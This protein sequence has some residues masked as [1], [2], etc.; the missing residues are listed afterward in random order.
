[1]TVLRNNG[2]GTFTTLA[3]P[4]TGQ[5]PI[6]VAVADFDRDGLPDLA[7]AD[8]NA[9]R[10][11]VLRNN[12]NG[13]FSTLATPATGAGPVCVA[14]A[15]FDRDGLP[16]LATA[17]LFSD[18]VT[19]LRNNGDGT[20]S[21]LATPATGSGPTSVA[22]A[23]FDRDGRP[24]LATA[25]RGSNRVTVLRAVFLELSAAPAA[26]DFPG[27]D[28]AAGPTS[29]KTSTVTNTGDDPV[30]LTAITLGGTDA[31]H[32]QRLTTDLADCSTSTT[33]AAGQACDLRVQ[34]DPATTGAKS[35]TLTVTS[36]A[37]DVTVALTGTGTQ[38]QLSVA[39]GSLDFDPQD[40]DNGATAPRTSTV[41]NT[42]TEPVAL[43]AIV[44]T[45]HTLDFER[46]TGNPTDC[47][48]GTSLIS[49]ETCDLRERFDPVSTGAKSA[50][51]T[52]E[53]N[54]APIAVALTGTGTQTQLSR[55][56]GSLSFQPR[57]ID[58]G[59]A[60]VQTSTVT[61]SGTESVAL[62]AITIGGPGAASFTR[63]TTNPTDCSTTTTL[64]AEQTCDLR[65]QFDPATTGAQTAT[66]TVKSS[67]PDLTVDLSGPG[68]QTQLSRTPTA[69]ALGSQDVDDGPTTP[70]QTSTVRNTGTEQVTLSAIT[71]GG[72]G[73]PSFARLT[74][75][76]ADCST[77]TTLNAGQTCTLRIQFDPATTGAQ[78]ATLTVTSNAAAIAV[79]LSGTGTQT[80]LSRSPTI[81]SFEP[82]DIDNGPAATQT[83]TVTNTGTER[84]TIGSITTTG[85]DFQRLTTN[86]ADCSET[87]TL[88]ADQTCT[89]RV[90]F[91]PETTGAKTGTVSVDSS[92]ADITVD[93][94]GTGTQTELSREPT[95]L[96]LGSQDIDN[97][98]TAPHTST[99]TNTGTQPVTISAITLTG[100]DA[101]S[102]QRLPNVGDCATSA[103]LA[104]GQTCELRVLFDPASVGAKSA[105]LTVKSNAA[106]VTVALSAT[107]TQTQLS[108]S[109]TALS[110]GSR[111]ID[112][113]PTAAQTSTVTN[114]GTEPV[115]ITA[116]TI[117]GTDAPRFERL[118][119]DPADCSTTTTLTAGQTCTLRVQLDPATTG[120]QTATLT[121][122]SNAAAIT[123]DLSGTGTQTQLSR[124]PA[125]LPF[126]PQD[127]DNGPTATQTSTVTNSGS[128]PVTIT[129]VTITGTDAPRFERLTTNPGD[130]STTTTLTAGQTCELRVRFDPVTTGATVA[131]LT[132]ASNAAAIT[133]DLSGT[134]TQTQ[135]SRSP[136]A[137]PFGPQDIDNGPTATQ[138]STVTNT[139]TE[140]VT[141]TAITLTGTGAAS[142]ARLTANP[143]DCATATLAAGQT[144]D[145]RVQFDPATT[146]AQTATLTVKSSVPDLTVTLSGT[147]TQTQLSRSPTALAFGSRDIDDGP[148]AAQ[149]ATV[150]NTGTEPVTLS[151]ITLAGTGAASFARL[152][153]NPADCSTTTTL[154]AGQTCTLRLQF[155]PDTTGAQSATLT[156]T[157]NAADI[158]VTLSGTGTQTE[159]SPSPGALSFGSRDIDD[160]ATA[161]QTSTVTNTGTQPVTLT[162]I[163]LAGSDPSQ[164]QRLTGA[165]GDCTTTTT[166]TAGQTCNL[167]ARFDPTAT[168]AKTATI[169]VTSN[170]AAI[171][172]T[173]SGTG[174]QT[175]LSRSPAALSFGLQD[176]DAGATAAQ[177]STVTNTG[178]EPVTLTAITLAGSDP[179]QFQRLTG[180]TA[181]CTTTTML[182]AGQTCD[183]RARFDPTSTG[184]K[185]ATITVDSN[186]AAIAV[187]LT[188][189][190]T[191][192]STE[193]SRAPAAL[194]FGSKDIDDGATATQAS[195]VTNTGTEPVT[196]T[197]I[198]LAGSNPGEFQLL[199]GAAVD[200]TTTTTLT[201]GETCDLRARFDPTSTGAKTATIT[202][203][204]NAADI[205]VSLTGTGTQA[206][207]S[208]SPTA[209]SFGPQ[210]IDAGATAAQASTVTNTGTEPVTFTAIT[211]GGADPDDFARLT[212]TAGDCASSTSLTSGQSCQLRVQF[213]PASVG[214]KSA[215]ATVTSNAADVV[216]TLSGTGTQ[217]QLSRAPDSLDLGPQD[218]DD[219]PT[220]AQTST[221]TNTGTEPV[222]ISAITI[223]GTDGPRFERL[224]TNL[225]D[226]S[227]ST[228]LAAGQT[229]DLR[230]RFD[231]ATIG[232]QT[233]TLTV[234]SNAAPVAVTL[235]GTGTQTQLSRSPTALSFGLQDIDNGATAAQT[236]T[237]TN[238][239]TEPVTLSAITLTG[240]ASFARLTTN[241]ADCS[242]TTT[243]TAGQTCTLRVQFDPATTG[244]QSAT[245]TVASDAADVAVTLTG[246][247]TQTELSRSPTAL[248]FGLQD[249]DNGATAP[250]TSTVTNTGTQPV[251]L[252]AITIGG[253][254][255]L[256][257]VRLTSNPADCS[258]TT[259]LTAGQTCD[260]RI[261]FDPATTGANTATITVKSNAP[262]ITVALSGTGTQTQLSRSP[263]SLAFAAQDIDEGATATQTSTVTNTGSEPVTLTAITLAG[264]DPGEFQRL[265]GA[266]ADCTTTTT[267][268]AGET[269]D[270]RA[271]FDPTTTGAKS[272]AL[273]A[274]SNAAAI[275]VTLTGTGT[276]T[277]L[278]R[279]PAA[280]PL[281]PQDIDTGA[282]AAQT[283]T[284]TNTG[285][286]PVT[287][288]AITI[289]GPDAP[290][291]QRLTTNPADCSTTTTLT[292]GLTCT[293]RVQFDPASTGAK[294]ATLT[295]A[296]NAA[297]IT[298]D[299]SGT[300]TQT[301]LSRS[302]TALAF[303]PQDID[304]GPTP[305][306]TSTVTNTG[307][308]PV[309][310]T[311]ITIGGA[312][313]PRFARLTG[314][315]G[316]CATTTLT[317]GQTCDLR[318][319]F[320][321]ATTGANVATLTVKSNAADVT[322]ALSGTGTQ[323]QL[324]RSPVAMSFG[325]RD[326]DDGPTAAQT[327]TVTN[328]GT[329]PVTLSAITLAGTGAA[330]FARLTTNP[331]DCTTTTTLA[332][333]QTCTLRVQFDPATTGAQTA[334]LNVTSNAADIAVTLTGSGT[335]TELSRS[336]TA[337]SFGPQD[338]DN[339]P[340][341]AQTSTV[342][343][344]GTQP[345]TLSAITIAGT[346]FQRLTTNPADCSTTTTLTA[347]QTCQLRV[348]FDPASTGATTATLTV[349]SNAAAITVGLSGTGTQMQLAR[350]PTALSFGSR[351]IDDGATATQASTVTNTGSEPVT[352]T[353]IT[354][355]GS[356]ASQFQR[357]TGATADCMTTTVL[358]AGETCDLRAR[359]DPTATGAK[360]ATLTVTSNAAAITVTLSG[361]G[362]Q[363]E[364]SRSP[365][366]LSLGPRDIDDGP[367][368]T[369][370]STVT[371]TGTQQVTLSAI[372][373]TGTDAPRFQRLTTNPADC[374][375]T[376]TLTAGQTCLLRVQFDPAATGA[377]T[378]LLTV[379][380]NAPDVTVALS[381]SGTQ[382][383]LSRS[384]A[385]LSFGPQDIDD[386]P[387]DTHTSTVTNTGTEPVTLTAITIAGADF[388]R[389]T[390]GLGDCSTSTTLAAGQACELR[391][392]FDPAT[393]GAKSAAITVDSSAADITVTLSGTGTQ[394]QLERTPT[395]LAFG[396]R[397]IDDGATAPQTSTVTNTG[398]EPVE[399][400]AIAITGTDAP[401]FQRLTTNPADCSTTSTLAAGQTCD[402]R[403]RFDPA[404]TGAQTATLTVTSEATGDLTVELSGS[405]TQTELSRSP[406]ALSFGPQ[407]ID[408]GA[409]ATQTSTVTNT[410]SEP[411]AFSGITLA[412]SDLSQFQR[413]TGAT[414]DCTTT[415]TL[416]AGETCILRAR[417]DPTSAG[418]KT[419]TI[420]VGSNADDSTVALSGTGT[421]TQLSRA[422]TALSFGSRGIDDGATTTQ[423]STVTNTGSEPVTL[424]AITLTGSDASQFQR[425]T[426]ATADCATTTVL[427]AGET[428]DLR[429]RFDPTATGAKSATLTVDSNAA[430]ITIT[431]TGT[432]TQTELSPDPGALSFGPRDID[433]G[434]TV[435]QAS[436]VTNT[437]SEPVTLTAIAL[438][439]TDPGHFAR[440]TGAASDCTTATT[441]TAGQTCDLRA[442]FDPAGT[443]PKAATLTV[444]SS[445]PVLTLTLTGTGTQA[446]LSPTP[447]TLSFGPRDVDDGPAAPQAS[448]ITNTGTEPVK[449][450][451][452][453]L[454]GTDPGQ[455]ARVTGD[456]ADCTTATTLSSGAT[457][458]L[459]ALYDPAATGAH[460]AT[461]MVSSDSAPI[462]VA[463]SGT[464]TQTGLSAAPDRLSFGPR[465]TA[466]GPS[467]T[468]TSTVTNIGSEPVTLTA[469]TLAGSDPGQFRRLTGA[470][471]DCAATTLSA[472][473]TCAVRAR[474]DPSSKGAKTATITVGSNATAVTVTLT[475]NETQ[476]GPTGGAGAG[477]A[478]CEGRLPTIVAKPGQ[479]VLTGTPGRDVIIGT[480]AADRIDG[481]GGN[482]TICAG[483]GND[484]VRGGAGDDVIRGG[485]G[486]DRLLGDSGRDVL[487]GGAGNDDLRGGDGR[488]TLGGG[489]GADRVDGG[490]GNDF[491]DDRKLG[492]DGEDRLLGGTGND[493]IATAG[494]TGDNVDC[495]PGK[496]SVTLDLKDRQRRCERIAR[497]HS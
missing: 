13:T 340:T 393:R 121:V 117:T 206:Q 72:T 309:T 155:D 32:F 59:P 254:A 164:F 424:A 468:Q 7:T 407:D 288:S 415:T 44:A 193:L 412:G 3:T 65:V 456:P 70:P 389:L 130:C 123:V 276:Q 152:T 295:V 358:A 42:G 118:T 2:N 319:Q 315:P 243:L 486:R 10:V 54:A 73:A 188:G 134:G 175:L 342:T 394:T 390:T 48:P 226:C 261:Q 149:T 494:S 370:T 86:P 268:A 492:G 235:S 429:T 57:D 221:V 68:T 464:G 146:G 37:P 195:T 471:T 191:N 434:P 162:A 418:T 297:A 62:T 52:V 9:N 441:L 411:V 34:F 219:G 273:T 425:L 458:L 449:L 280:L 247:G 364:L 303:G 467:A 301:E 447:A 455:F 83:S 93:L 417:F 264:S 252:S 4:A 187:T 359:F 136:A 6:S 259:T 182:T 91:D 265:T 163:T 153:T 283:A 405:G 377:K 229:C 212:G 101:P 98:P 314:N 481:R 445:E 196:L 95:A 200:C 63:L 327:S 313:A 290:Q 312:D 35:A 237:V 331:A 306:Q 217:T 169:T 51:L 177:T 448:A 210:D 166:L 238:T 218:I 436:T 367:T 348:Q 493:R 354:L 356:D 184:A 215:T 460:T 21:T 168:G 282:T 102:F 428:C 488:D 213:D 423:A 236:S 36:N 402:L 116:L 145:L 55:T 179:S 109:P 234:T 442:R 113:G 311:A 103:T 469:I 197:A 122:T 304:N 495:G 274:T 131:T 355:T 262:D 143:T 246:T 335:Q 96:S 292:A 46:L 232:A 414:A 363:T 371:N 158:A 125:A 82:Q 352:L 289:T 345:V 110:F 167:R 318:V 223:A 126:G 275:T 74:T 388:Q 344:S 207:L 160:G 478:M 205:T 245:L 185:T 332:A 114:T 286:E 267:L 171:T 120:A 144:C 69:L 336:P 381:G 298:V 148:A 365:T 190:G 111:D 258:A 208:R 16:D 321:P 395:A 397:D 287:L 137:L 29:T 170:A 260:L 204:S 56:P 151:A 369:Q 81:L 491:L 413:L 150:T 368:A 20:F 375:T 346:G 484:T 115:T 293:L 462:S 97:G 374:A 128:E 71:I 378:A 76:P 387:T 497:I 105:T 281:G 487:L 135:L 77:T 249:I 100:T 88:T 106:D 366:A 466:A 404:T 45:G 446:E 483:R 64:T 343:N 272:A 240:A 433:D 453:T 338:I 410:G 67:V 58:D 183:L 408:D 333:G 470:T 341:A 147:G 426:G 26:L 139:G 112:D 454:G 350:S 451:A 320:D 159:L 47:M 440:V 85:T 84:V 92:A 239:G 472:G 337:L 326:I 349:T 60:A 25:D 161:T 291:F 299:L 473:E 216:V 435:T 476:A 189:T 432:G 28:I 372:A 257:F 248:S 225:T 1:V 416:T 459:R 230:V 14:V 496:D 12:G 317:A 351:D 399:L 285:T 270:L 79:D 316:D 199:T 250:Q 450:G 133:V 49:G 132:V 228:T 330:S 40:I 18:R 119:T 398:T 269:C 156:V 479:T 353:A 324:S 209:L 421:Q 80:E 176:I 474:F 362:I 384:P 241:P 325:S 181:D 307:T 380:S 357:L 53:S 430:A 419:A 222:A 465:D 328:T 256:R 31:A 443:G 99:V 438:T 24:D 186:A 383:E 174:T 142:F 30:A 296:S 475:G 78:S 22:V 373:I 485:A 409:A 244:A 329:E 489:S 141:L 334:T 140:P 242:T 138:T 439:G 480:D 396:P 127:I 104:A 89:L 305:A 457:C 90:Q 192:I 403:V 386:G 50:T 233:A 38:T 23:D 279:S 444:T 11:T 43:T 266:T 422:P 360:S 452:I 255:A 94:S 180:A 482:D 66:L 406:A 376:T 431:L 8:F 392:R 220:A 490:A 194:S 401:R 107:G 382:A 347:G 201:A 173:L 224:T 157:S 178:S 379:A 251:T 391:V 27:R 154:T 227:T 15:D 5:Q 308:Q 302:P 198:T 33:L 420:T 284:V 278:S 323:T 277:E 124:S 300:G 427:A 437:G 231:P 361:T 172:V 19:V 461:V 202:V 463:L 39:P 211:L 310:I 477:G 87:T 263:G 271:H 214:A 129:A 75:N 165:S 322:V 17:D 400:T 339:G 61:N 108:R 41:T 253:A 294:A 203:D 385:A